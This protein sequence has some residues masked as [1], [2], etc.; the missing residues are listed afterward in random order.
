[1]FMSILLSFA[2]SKDLSSHYEKPYKNY[3]SQELLSQAKPLWEYYFYF[4]DCRLQR[5]KMFPSLLREVY[6][7]NIEESIGDYL[8][9]KSH[10]SNLEILRKTH[11][12]YSPRNFKKERNK[13]IKKSTST[14]TL[15][16]N[17]QEKP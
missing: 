3:F 7:K 6:I 4:D 10:F 12:C 17:F 15:F 13:K 1:M 8:K 16:H 9:I 2:Y 14:Q 5:E 11:I